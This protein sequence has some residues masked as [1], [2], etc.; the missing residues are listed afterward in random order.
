MFALG[1]ILG[2]LDKVPAVVA[3]IPEFKQTFDS[4]VATFNTKD[5]DVLKQRYDELIAENDEGHARLQE[6]L[7]KAEQE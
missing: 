5:Q 4:I 3:A 7:G 2:L 1:T 6:K